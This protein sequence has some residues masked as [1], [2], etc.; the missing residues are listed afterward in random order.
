M[1]TARFQH[2]AV[3]ATDLENAWRWL[4]DPNTWAGMAGVRDI[5]NVGR[6]P[7]GDLISFEFVAMVAGRPYA[8]LATT[9]T[10]DFPHAMSLR[11]KSKE[12]EGIVAAALTSSEEGGV[13]VEADLELEAKGLMAS[14]FFS[15]ITGVVGTGFPEQVEEFAGRLA[16][17]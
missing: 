7:A 6:S 2:H 4:Q 3:A 14:M 16:G 5:D 11:I 12:L 17:S 15:V 9:L 1:P 13:L 10:A 8:G